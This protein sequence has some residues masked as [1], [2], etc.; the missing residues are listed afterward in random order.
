MRSDRRHELETNDLA[1]T[2]AVLAERVRPY[3]GTIA[4]A[5]AALAVGGGVWSL[6]ESRR[7]ATRQ[8]SWEAVLAAL[9]SGQPTM[10][11]T[12]VARYP[13]TPAAQWGRLV[14]AEE[15]LDQGSQALY[16]DRALADQRLR[17]AE[18]IYVALLASGPLDF[19]AERATFGLAKAR[20]NLGSLDEARRGYE[21]VV[22]E[23]PGSAVKRFAA[24]RVAALG[25]EST[26]QWYDWFIQQKPVPPRA[27]GAATES[28]APTAGPEAERPADAGTGT[29]ASG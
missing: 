26:R 21:A 8:E 17:A 23:H 2:A 6:V 24:E 22:R 13:G 28:T 20:E 9:S 5:V 11:D 7:V 10:L 3:L 12:A 16:V 25:R 27:D 4:V 19:V 14:T 1:D 29:D 15:L 18:S